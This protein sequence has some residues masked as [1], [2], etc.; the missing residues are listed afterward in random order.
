MATLRNTES[1]DIHTP[2]NDSLN[3]SELLPTGVPLHAFGSIENHDGLSLTRQEINRLILEYLV[4]EGYKDAAEKFSRET[5]ITEPLTEMRISGESLM[6]RMWIREAVLRR[7]IADVIEKVNSL[8][9][10]LFDKNP[11]IYFQLRQLQMLELIR[12]HK[13]EDALIFAQSYLADPVAK[14]LSDHPQLLNEMQNTMALLAFDDP[15]QSIYGCLLGPQHAELVAGALNRAIL[16]HI[17]ASGDDLD[18]I[19]E[20]KT[21]TAAN[22]IGYSGTSSTVPRLTKMMAMLLHFRELAQL[23]LPSEL[24]SL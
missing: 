7:N 12:N 22:T 8:W 15:A 2:D 14:R 9:P 20:G 19:D 17:E 18:G 23:E 5:G 6:D 1:D 11:F 24:A 3:A 16:R 21:S 4:V 13:L 10:E